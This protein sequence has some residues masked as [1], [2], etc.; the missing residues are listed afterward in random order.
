MRILVVPKPVRVPML[1]RQKDGTIQRTEDEVTFVDFLK[2]A[3]Q[4]FDGFCYAKNL[5]I[6]KKILAVLNAGPKQEGPH[7]VLHFSEG[8]YKNLCDAVRGSKWLTPEVNLAYDPYYEAV[9]TAKAH[10]K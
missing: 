2:I 1:I 10:S 5:P 3:C 7:M 6:L 8:D 9:Y 4:N